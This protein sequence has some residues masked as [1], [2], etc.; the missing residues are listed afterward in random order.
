MP[1]QRGESPSRTTLLL[2]R[3]ADSEVLLKVIGDALVGAHAAGVIRVINRRKMLVGR[4]G[5][6]LLGRPAEAAAS[7]S[8]RHCHLAFRAGDFA[9]S[10]TAVMG[11]GLDLHGRRRD[12]GKFPLD[13][14]SSS[15]NAEDGQLVTKWCVT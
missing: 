11:A 13:L 4:G 8:M 3:A 12:A 5:S 1:S 2:R 10:R 15:I 7:D 6:E 9:D 14:S